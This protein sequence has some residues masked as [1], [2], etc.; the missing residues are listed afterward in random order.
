MSKKTR[1][2][3]LLLGFVFFILFAPI[4]VFYV[5]GLKYDLKTGKFESTGILAMRSTPSSVN[6]LLNGKIVRKSDGDI[7][8]L[9]PGEYNLSLQKKRLP[10][11]VKTLCGQTK[12]SHLGQPG[13]KQ[14]IFV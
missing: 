13:T 7:K 8:F 9:L 10:A 11:L 14:F 6:V 5:T 12:R 3:L 1:Y 2:L 4:M